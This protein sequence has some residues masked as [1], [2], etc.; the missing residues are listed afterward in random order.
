MALVK[1]KMMMK[2]IYQLKNCNGKTI[3]FQKKIFNKVNEDKLN[4]DSFNRYQHELR[5]RK[6]S[7]D[8][9]LF[10]GRGNK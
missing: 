10:R 1:I 7:H 5:T 2:T 3:F 6:E 9:N 8:L 4:K